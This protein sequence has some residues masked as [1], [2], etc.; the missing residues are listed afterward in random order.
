MGK[1]YRRDSEF[2]KNSKGS[3]KK[4]NKSKKQK[5]SDYDG[6][7]KTVESNDEIDNAY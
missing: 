4:E 5:F 7:K 2:R 3:S 1:T 6:K